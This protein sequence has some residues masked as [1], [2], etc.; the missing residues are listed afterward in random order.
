MMSVLCYRLPKSYRCLQ[1]V[2]PNKNPDVKVPDG[3]LPGLMALQGHG[4]HRN[5]KDMVILNDCQW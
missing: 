2:R 1:M 5:K 3:K 4:N